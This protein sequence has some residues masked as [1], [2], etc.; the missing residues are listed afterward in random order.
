[1]Q[2]I[3][4]YLNRTPPVERDLRAK[5]L[6]IARLEDALRL[7]LRAHTDDDLIAARLTALRVLNERK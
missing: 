3:I 7:V 4:N 6:R 1:V 2:A 5:D